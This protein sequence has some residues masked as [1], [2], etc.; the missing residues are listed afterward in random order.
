MVS[1][2]GVT[3][4]QRSEPTKIEVYSTS[5]VK[6]KTEQPLQIGM[7]EIKVRDFATLECEIVFSWNKTY[8]YIWEN[9]AEQNFK[10]Q[11]EFPD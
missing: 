10:L 6:K 4:A 11:F 3:S 8:N 2:F 9:L 1:L 5:I 7:V